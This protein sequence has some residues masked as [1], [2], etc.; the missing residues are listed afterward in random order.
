VSDLDFFAET[1][2]GDLAL[3]P[4]IVRRPS[5]LRRKPKHRVVPVEQPRV[6]IVAALSARWL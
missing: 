2:M 6:L 4:E 1:P 3:F 5:S